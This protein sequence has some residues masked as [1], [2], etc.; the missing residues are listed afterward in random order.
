MA[1]E[2]GL[3]AAGL[4]WVRR[5]AGPF[6]WCLDDDRW[7]GRTMCGRLRQTEARWESLSH[8]DGPTESRLQCPE[9]IRELDARP[10][11]VAAEAVAAAATPM[12]PAMATVH[13]DLHGAMGEVAARFE[14][15]RLATTILQAPEVTRSAIDGFALTVREYLRAM[16]AALA[17]PS[18]QEERAATVAWLRRDPL[19]RIAQAYAQWIELGLHRGETVREQQAALDAAHASKER[20]ESARAELLLAGKRLGEV[21][22]RIEEARQRRGSSY[23]VIEEDDRD[24]LSDLGAALVEYFRAKG[25]AQ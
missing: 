1:S 15:L 3:T 18:A 23:G 24:F 17:A 4:Q 25:V 2:E 22:D 8:E 14:L 19:A 7:P 6:V 16:P 11:A 5:I 9:C 13:E 10:V 12:S 21:A 20:D